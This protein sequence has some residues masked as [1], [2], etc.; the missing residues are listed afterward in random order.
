MAN[1]IQIKRSTANATVPSL[2]AGELAYTA[3]GDVLF[4]G[5]PDGVSGNIRIGG[6]QTP[7]V[8]TANQAIVANSTS[9][10]DSLITGSF[11]LNTYNITTIIDDDSFAT[12]VSNTSIATSEAIK[13]YV[14]SV[15]GAGVSVLSDITDVNAGTPT[16]GHVLTWDQTEAKWVDADIAG[17]TGITS[18][19]SNT[20]DTHTISLNNTTVA[21]GAY[22][23][24]NTVAS[25]TVDA[26][27]RL[28]VATNVDINHDTLLNFVANEHI[29]H[30]T[31]S[32]IAGNG[33]TGGGTIAADR[34]LTVGAGFGISVNATAVAINANSG[35][36][37]NSTGLFVNTSGDSSLVANSTGVHVIDSTLSIATTQ[38]TGDV[39]LGT[40][41]SGNYVATITAGNGITGSGTGEGSTP[42]LAVQAA[43]NT[44]SVGAG[45]IAVNENNL[46]IATSQ[47]TGDVVLGTGT[48][49]NYV[50]T[51]TGTANEIE[52]TGSG[53]ETAAVTIGLPDDVTIG[54]NLT[55]TGNLVVSG[56]STTINTTQ[57]LVEDNMIGLA[58]NNAADAVDF[59]FY[60]QYNDG[61]EKF[62]GLLRDAS[63]T[64]TWKL[65]EGITVEPTGTT[66]TGGTLAALDI[67]ALSAGATTLSSLSLTTDLAVAHGGTGKSSF[68]TNG[69]VFGA[70]TSAL[71]VTAAGTSGQVLQ[72]GAGGVPVF[73]SLDGG[74]F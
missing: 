52:V 12:G 9:G 58:V 1:L 51:I 10:V 31:V 54:R 59:G 18:S 28:T 5:H 19:Y 32:V 61:T 49:G 44:I 56:T 55:V 40:Q 67:G 17:G 39:V 23:D 70:G 47:L 24:A 14:D 34:T 69:I 60:G 73:G 35:L 43:N 64:G 65:L 30:S 8:L 16:E 7:G 46:S 48:S 6:E 50:A 29:D 38:L 3:N 15:A 68:T 11:T 57:L 45:G 25:F 20:T 74:T 22:G 66:F 36:T 37:A 2:S 26:Q 27:G 53:S 13:S 42:T 33:L 71:S 21:A 62:S 72:A 41:T 4:I 63:D